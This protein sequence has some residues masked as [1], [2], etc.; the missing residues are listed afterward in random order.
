MIIIKKVTLWHRIKRRLFATP[1]L[2]VN[3]NG[4]YAFGYLWKNGMIEIVDCGISNFVG[5]KSY[6][7]KAKHIFIEGG[8]YVTR[9]NNTREQN[10][11]NQKL[12]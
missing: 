1:F 6:L 3:L 10:Q 7:D 11:N 8:L 9:T 12:H 2:S 4:A 5:I